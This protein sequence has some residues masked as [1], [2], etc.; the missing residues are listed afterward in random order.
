LKNKISQIKEKERKGKKKSS[1]RCIGKIIL[2]IFSFRKD[3]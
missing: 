2:G 3:K 1:L